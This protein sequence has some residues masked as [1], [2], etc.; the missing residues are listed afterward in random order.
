M[1]TRYAILMLAVMMLAAPPALA[2][3]PTPVTV[4]TDQGPCNIVYIYT[5]IPPDV[6]V[7]EECIWLLL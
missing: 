6:E 2:D 4:P 7:H 3:E 5:T 1:Q